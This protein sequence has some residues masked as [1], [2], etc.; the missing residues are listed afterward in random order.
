ME[1]GADVEI[2]R[3][4]E[5]VEKETP[6]FVWRISAQGWLWRL[7]RIIFGMSLV[8]VNMFNKEK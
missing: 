1:G 4:M 6:A 3:V 2:A 5:N 7:W 8:T